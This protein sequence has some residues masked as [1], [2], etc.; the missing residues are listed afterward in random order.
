[1]RLI[2]VMFTMLAMA[3]AGTC[4]PTPNLEEYP[5]NKIWLEGRAGTQ[6][7]RMYLERG[8]KAAIGV[9]YNTTDWDPVMLGGRWTESDSIELSEENEGGPGNG[10]LKGQLTSGGFTGIWET[11]LRNQGL[12]VLLKSTS[13]PDC[14]GKG[15]WVLFS[16]TR[17]PITFSYPASWHLKTS[18]D[19]V[20]LTCPDPSLMAYE[21]FG[22]TVAKGIQPNPEGMGFIQCGGKWRY[23]DDCDCDSPDCGAASIRHREGMAILGGDGDRREYRIYCRY[24][25]YTGAGDDAQVVLLISNEWVQFEGGGPSVALVERILTTATRQP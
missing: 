21:G 13:R 4:P 3:S 6:D 24:G 14:T 9:F 8:G 18:D 22:I 7:I 23:G 15:P 11:S 1:M 5:N 25:G 16:D 12:P 17:W 2:L 20:I 10:L 19:S